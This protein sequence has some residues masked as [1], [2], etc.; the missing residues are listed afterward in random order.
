MCAVRCMMYAQCC[1]MLSGVKYN[2]KGPIRV[3]NISLSPL[4]PYQI[5]DKGGKKRNPLNANHPSSSSS[6]SSPL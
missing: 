6:S 4:L 1:I 3:S 5:D 2:F